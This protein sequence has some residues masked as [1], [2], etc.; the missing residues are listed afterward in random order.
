VA[1]K[2]VCARITGRVQGVWF[3]AWT[4]DNAGELGLSGWVRNRRDGSVEALF[5]GEAKDVDEMLRRC[6]DGPPQAQVDAVE[7]AP[8]DDPGDTGFALARTG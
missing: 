3:R 4:M 1:R 8:A 7:P 2:A 5:A 6:H